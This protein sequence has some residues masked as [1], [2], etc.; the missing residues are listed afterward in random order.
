MN[1]L[2]NKKTVVIVKDF[3]RNIDPN[4]S[5]MILDANARSAKEAA[6]SLNVEVGSIVKSIILKSVNNNFF[7]C[8]V[9]GDKTVS[10]N[11]ISELAN[12]NIV[13]PNADEV[14][15]VTGF[16]IGGV[17]PFA[18]KNTIPTYIDESLSRFKS[19]YA[20]AGHPY[21]VF[22]ITYDKL[23]KITKGTIEDIVD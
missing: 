18:H 1:K 16:S 11:K 21:C 10:I 4:L 6:I 7:I 3:L 20:A 22:K 19:I 2:T 17:P 15:H 14:K 23:C 12:S 9:S 5:I 13:K 8:L